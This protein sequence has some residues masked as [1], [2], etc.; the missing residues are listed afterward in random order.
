MTAA[1][2]PVRWTV[3]L[4]VV[5]LAVVLLM[6]ACAASKPRIEPPP[7]APPPL[8]ASYDWHV[9]VVAP[10]GSV[11]KD[12]PLATHEVLLFRDSASGAPAGD[13]PE[14]YAVNGT[15]PRFM[16]RQPSEY[17]LCFKHDRLSRVEATV[18]LPTDRTEQ[19]LADACGLW[20]TSAQALAKADVPKTEAPKTEAPSLGGCAGIE[21]NVAFVAGIERSPDDTDTQLTIQL[22]ATD[23]ASDAAADRARR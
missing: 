4:A 15:A 11:L 22:D 3:P 17:L 23:L 14:C 10:F 18:L 7:P 9:L 16:A 1:L 5:P 8:D 20:M 12:V 2:I 19:I 6:A 13:E 21:G